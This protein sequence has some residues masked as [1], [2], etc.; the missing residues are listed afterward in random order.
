MELLFLEGIW[1]K[2]REIGA[3]KKVTPCAFGIHGGGEKEILSFRMADSE[4]LPSL[5]GVLGRFPGP[6]PFR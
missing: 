4:D 6:G 3:G 1:E 2:A 5:K